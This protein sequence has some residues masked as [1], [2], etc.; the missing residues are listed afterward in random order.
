MGMRHTVRVVVVVGDGDLEVSEHS[1]ALVVVLRRT[2]EHLGCPSRRQLA[3][4]FQVDGIAGIRRD[5]DVVVL[6]RRPAA[7]ARIVSVAFAGFV[8]HAVPVRRLP[9]GQVDVVPSQG[10]SGRLA[11]LVIEVVLD[12]PPAAALFRGSG[13][14]H[15][16]QNM[17]PL[18]LA[19]LFESISLRKSSHSSFIALK[20]CAINVSIS[21]IGT[22]LSTT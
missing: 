13:D 11:E 3:Q 5:D 20:S 4:R 12:P 21:S 14:Q 2:A 10:P 9:V 16:H 18:I 22:S 17:P 15:G 19:Q 6:P 8:H 7:P 1:H